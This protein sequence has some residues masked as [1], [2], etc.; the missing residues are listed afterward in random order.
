MP[1]TNTRAGVR[2]A[3]TARRLFATRESGLRV[4]ATADGVPYGGRVPVAGPWYLT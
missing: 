3:M 1:T 4:A 2:E